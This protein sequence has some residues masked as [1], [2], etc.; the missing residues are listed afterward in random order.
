MHNGYG[1]GMEGTRETF[2]SAPNNK[3]TSQYKREKHKIEHLTNDLYG[4]E[5]VGGE[6]SHYISNDVN[7]RIVK[8]SGLSPVSYD[9][10]D[11]ID[12]INKVG[13]VQYIKQFPP[14]LSENSANGYRKNDIWYDSVNG[15]TYV[16]KDAVSFT[17]EWIIV[18]GEPPMAGEVEA[19]RY[20]KFVNPHPQTSLFRRGASVG[21]TPGETDSMTSAPYLNTYQ[22]EH[23]AAN[24]RPLVSLIASNVV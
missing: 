9:E 17:P 21:S 15:N 6:M 23:A 19:N 11:L 24:S 13:G 3:K 10:L 5:D 14:G 1:E 4:D 16:L 12:F 20:A 22:R 7:K 8:N 2:T 18:R